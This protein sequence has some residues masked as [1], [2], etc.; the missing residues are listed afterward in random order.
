MTI[1]SRMAISKMQKAEGS[2]YDTDDE[3]DWEAVEGADGLYYKHH[4]TSPALKYS[5]QVHALL[6]K[7]D[8][9]NKILERSQVSSSYIA[10]LFIFSLK[11]ITI[12]RL[13]SNIDFPL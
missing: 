3:E 5:D 8:A 13:W 9:I 6:P 12:W 4:Y 7:N 11:N 2:D 10:C 1:G